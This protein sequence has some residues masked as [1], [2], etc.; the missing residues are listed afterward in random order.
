MKNC[1]MRTAPRNVPA[2]AM[3]ETTTIR[4]AEGEGGGRRNVPQASKSVK[5]LSPIT[6]NKSF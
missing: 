4:T 6:H 3:N 2:L 5:S 1:A